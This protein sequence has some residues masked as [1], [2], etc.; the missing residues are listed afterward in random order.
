MN[1]GNH[2]HALLERCKSVLESW[3]Q[4]HRE[5][6]GSHR[7]P[8]GATGSHREPQK[9]TQRIHRNPG[10]HTHA[11]LER[12]KGVLECWAKTHRE[13]Q[14]ATGGHTDKTQSHREP[15]GATVNQRGPH[16]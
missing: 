14:G 1:T 6:Q 12:C 5:P 13:P 3:T 10:S 16:R 9:A 8:Q 7:E 2:S 15:Q 4:T 11:L